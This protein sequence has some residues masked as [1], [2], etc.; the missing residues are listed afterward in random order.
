VPDGCV[1]CHGLEPD[2]ALVN[3]L[4]TDHWFD[5][6]TNDFTRV[7]DEGLHVLVDAGTDDT[8]KLEFQRAFDVIRQFNKEVEIQNLRAQPKSFHHEAAATW[9]KLHETSNEH[10]E[11]TQRNVNP[12][13]LWSADSP[14]DKETLEL[15]NQYCFR[16]HGSVKFDVFDKAM[17]FDP[18]RF[19][20]IFD[21]LRPTSEQLRLDP[22]YRM[23][24]DR[25]LDDAT[26][27]RLF[28][29]LRH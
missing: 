26:L 28:N 14:K 19:G 3:Y 6:V 29:L 10:F 18:E 25:R 16:C 12:T 15:L 24:P 5:R 27:D 8:S 13:V 20:L 22:G 4:D 7:R 1:A 9:L 2:K 21:R 17:V 23:P 11:P